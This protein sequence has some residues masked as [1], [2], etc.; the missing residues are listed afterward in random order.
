MSNPSA[1]PGTIDTLSVIMAVYNEAPT[2]KKAVD[3]VLYADLPAGTEIQLIIVESN[4]TDETRGMVTS[5]DDPRLKVVLQDEPK[6]KGNA[7]R[8]GLKYVTGQVV[9]LQ[10][11]DLEY[12][13]EDYQVLLAPISA[14]EAEFVLGSRH[15]KGKPMREFAGDHLTSRLLNAGHWVFTGLFNA[16]YGTRLRD[17]YTMYKVFR[18]E[19]I[20][21]M[22]FVS[23]RFDFDIELVAK[24]VRRGYVPIE[25][26]VTYH[27]RGYD[28]GKK[29]RLI[30]DPLTWIVALIR[31]RFA[32][33]G[34]SSPSR[35]IA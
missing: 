14:G 31:F 23:N 19:C 2:V 10:D 7:V 8:T 27:S 17:P 5:Y 3:A 22:D 18:T 11:G 16:I 6:G 34:G 35:D 1:P 20:E 9:L 21:G 29:V 4:S 12:S 28:E 26:P 25:V 30:W 15:A 13:V 32:S 24:L 33:L